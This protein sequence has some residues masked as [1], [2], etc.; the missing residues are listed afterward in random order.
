MFSKGATWRWGQAR[1]TTSLTVCNTGSRCLGAAP[2]HIDPDVA[3]TQ[4]HGLQSRNYLPSPPQ[5]TIYAMERVGIPS[6]DQQ[7]IFRTV[8]AILQLGN[9]S[10][11]WVRKRARRMAHATA[12]VPWYGGL[13]A[14]G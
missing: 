11:R 4:F 5:R 14:R 8:A 13:T 6:A 9:I 10:F 7:A 12:A 3:G 1:H 2:D